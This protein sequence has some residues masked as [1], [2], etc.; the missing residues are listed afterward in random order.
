MKL[1]I[2]TDKEIKEEARKR[3]K[4]MGKVFKGSIKRGKT[5]LFGIK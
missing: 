3:T 2:Y 5:G 4:G 1:K